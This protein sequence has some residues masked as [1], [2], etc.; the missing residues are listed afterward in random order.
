MSKGTMSKGWK[1][2]PGDCLEVMATLRAGSVR[3]IFADPPYNQGVDYGPHHDDEMTP[4]AYLAW[5]QSWFNAAVR[6]LTPDGSLW[7]LV[8]HEWAWQLVPIAKGAGLDLRQ[9]VTWYETFGV[10]CTRKFNRTSRP[11]LWFVRN[12]ARFVFNPD[13]VRRLSD[14]QTK[15]NDKRANPDGKLWDDVWTIPR[16]A[17]TH[18]E[19]IRDFPTQLP[20]RLLRPIVGC[21]SDPGDLVLDPFAGSGT[22]GQAAVELGRRY[23]GIERGERF[24][25]RA[26]MRLEGLLALA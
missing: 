16:V 23:T 9:W 18:G 19:R 11:L 20:V 8:S 3:L 17:G 21:A 7:L 2:I 15:Y 25:A 10:N 5:C 22:S 12:P 1:I 24:A 13:A 4:A 14:R 6:L 26:K